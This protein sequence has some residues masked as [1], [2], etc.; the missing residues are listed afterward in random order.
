[1]NA[2]SVWFATGPAI[3]LTLQITNMKCS[4]KP[5]AFIAAIFSLVAATAQKPALEKIWETDS[6]LATP[7]SVLLTGGALYVSLIDGSPWEADGRGGIAKMDPN[8]KNIQSS[9][10]TGLNAPKGMAAAGNLLYVADL[11]EVVVIDMNKVSIIQKIPI[12]NA[13]GL[14]D[15]TI[16]D[17]GIIYVSDSR[18]AK[19][20]RIESGQPKLFL[21]G[22][23]GINGLKAVDDKLYIGAGPLFANV[24]ADGKIEKIATVTQGIDG[25][26]PT[27]DGDFVLTAWPGYIWY[28]HHDGR[29]ETL[30]ETHEQ[31][32]NSADIG[33]DPEKK[34]VYVPTFFGKTVAAYQLK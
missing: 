23:D 27:G 2:N 31:K 34:I 9:W 3:F 30:L 24:S 16:D 1:M 8:G 5:T 22:Q 12:E 4:A 10:V 14:N 33:Y 21:D 26:E 32:I 19:I 20:W 29:V 28:V 15:V 11:S 7:E 13:S 6:V 25:I 17:K 18:T